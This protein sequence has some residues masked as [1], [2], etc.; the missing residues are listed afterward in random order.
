LELYPFL[1]E[2]IKIEDQ[3]WDDNVAPLV[4][5]SCITFNHANYIRNAIEGFLLQ[6]TTFK[7]EILI[8]DDASLDC[9]SDIIRSYEDRYP[10]VIKPIYE[11]DNQYSKTGLT[12]SHLELARA[13]GKYIALCEGDD[14]WTDPL[15]LQ[16]QV[17]FMEEN[18]D[19]GMVHS[20]YLLQDDNQNTF[21]KIKTQ[22]NHAD[23][24]LAW[25]IIGQELFIGTSSIL[26]R[27]ELHHKIINDFANDYS[28]GPIGDTQTWFH[29][30]R[31]SN[32]GYIDEILSVYRKSSSGVTG[33]AN[34]TKRITFLENALKLDLYLA[35]TYNA[36]GKW[37]EKIRYKFSRSILIESLINA[38][39]FRIK[40]YGKEIFKNEHLKLWLLQQ[41]P[42]VP[43]AK[44][45]LINTFLMIFKK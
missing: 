37:K 30:A 32:I 21:Q 10:K 35:E 11:K 40:K 26:S 27:S 39:T 4:S 13:R 3:H 41:L 23:K 9:T 36:P 29:F 22:I 28:L 25:R 20:A 17:D 19:V 42:L 34:T 24:D 2:P 18:P 38:D 31:I 15:K 1:Q 5:I 16:K 45:H 8:H 33:S 14:Y 7:I 44:R 6:K 43:F 12:F